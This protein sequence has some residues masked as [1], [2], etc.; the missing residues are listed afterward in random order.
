VLSGLSWVM[1]KK[2]RRRRMP[3]KPVGGREKF[4]RD[5]SSRWSGFQDAGREALTTQGRALFFRRRGC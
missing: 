3:Q 1:E 4:G 5:W 2:H